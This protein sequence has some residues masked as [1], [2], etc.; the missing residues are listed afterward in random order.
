[1]TIYILGFYGL[2]VLLLNPA[3]VPNTA[4]TIDGTQWKYLHIIFKK[5]GS[6]F[7]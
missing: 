7:N 1:M 6:L 3:T 4:L 5:I 2:R